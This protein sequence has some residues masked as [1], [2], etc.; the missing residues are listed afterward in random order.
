MV[1]RTPRQVSGLITL[2]LLGPSLQKP[3]VRVGSGTDAKVG[4][5]KKEEDTIALPASS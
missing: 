4:L 2:Q 5:V 1:S 3:L